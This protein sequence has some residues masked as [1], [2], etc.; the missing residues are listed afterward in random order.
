M[1][2]PSS[3]T[4][5]SSTLESVC[6]QYG[7]CISTPLVLGVNRGAG[8]VLGTDWVW[9]WIVLWTCVGNQPQPV[10]ESHPCNY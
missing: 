1:L 7:Q 5:E 3:A 6:R 8:D 4:R 2:P 10:D 9:L